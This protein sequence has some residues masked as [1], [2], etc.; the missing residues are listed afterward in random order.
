MKAMNSL[1]GIRG[2]SAKIIATARK[3]VLCVTLLAVFQMFVSPS[4]A[5][6]ITNGDFETGTLAGWSTFLTSSGTLGPLP[7]V[8]L[9]DTNGDGNSSLS[10]QFQVG[11][12]FLIGEQGGGIFQTFTTSAT[13]LIISVDIAADI[14][15]ITGNAAAGIFTLFLDSV[16]VDSH[17]FGPIL[18]SDAGPEFGAERASLNFSGSVDVGLHEIRILMT[19]AFEIGDNTPIQ[20]IDNVLIVDANAPVP[21]PF[22]SAL[23]AIGLVGLAWS[24]RARAAHKRK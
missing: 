23:L 21:E 9:F 15:P 18:G 20:Y 8:V 22:T 12:G 5:A 6:L 11:G 2:R 19:R 7:N 16:A 24:R 17:D 13:S 1:A 4:S 14:I 10:A 3:G